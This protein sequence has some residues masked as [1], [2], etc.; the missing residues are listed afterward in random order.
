MLSL[1]SSS[2]D[3]IGLHH[4]TLLS[5]RSTTALIL[6]HVN[7]TATEKVMCMYNVHNVL[8]NRVKVEVIKMQMYIYLR[9]II[10]CLLH[11]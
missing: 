5:G 7:P 10:S 2:L 6:Y 3:L 4:L 1:S 8:T 11:V 9:T